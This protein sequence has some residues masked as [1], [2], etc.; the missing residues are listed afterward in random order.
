MKSV[1]YSDTAREIEFRPDSLF[2][3]Y[4]S[5]LEK[6]VIVEFRNSRDL[7]VSCC[8]ACLCNESSKAFE[9]FGFV[10][11]E[12]QSCNTVYMSP[13]PDDNAIKKHYI[14]SASS[15]F[16]REKLSM[17]TGEK[18][19]EIIYLPRLQW[20]IDIAEE[21]LPHA[22][23]VA[24]FCD[25]NRDYIREFLQSSF[26][27]NKIIVNPYVKTDEIFVG[28]ESVQIVT[29]YALA[30]QHKKRVDIVTAFE[31]IDCT[32]DVNLLLK[33]VKD[34]LVPGGLF[35]ITTISIS[36]FDLQVLWEHSK[37]IIP[38]DRINVFSHVGLTELFKRY[39]FEVLEFS[40][41]GRLDLDIVRNALKNNA[42]LPV[43][44]FIKALVSRED[45]QLDNDFQEF[46]QIN[47]LSSF[48]RVVLRKK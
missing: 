12:C 32:S 38:P 5:L 28:N 37:S 42:E 23:T 9:K 34:I 27:D 46:L 45:E 7:H 10:Y 31:V 41:P 35:F 29:D 19:K 21:F 40:T 11:L 18:R 2:K 25:R 8:P 17:S 20:I 36:G 33:T 24:D 26:V 16:W 1:V 15:C 4:L 22:K 6:D 3:E 43:P 39:D 48:V 13:R 44:R 14:G 30:S 47:K